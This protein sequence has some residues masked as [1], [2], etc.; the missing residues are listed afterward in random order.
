MSSIRQRL[1]ERLKAGVVALFL[2]GALGG[3]FDVRLD[4]QR[5][6]RPQPRPDLCQKRALPIYCHTKTTCILFVCQSWA[7]YR[8]EDAG[9]GDGSGG[10]G[11][12]DSDSGWLACAQDCND[13]F[14]EGE[15]WAE[16][17]SQCEVE[18]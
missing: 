10:N 4:A 6:G 12:G 7:Y 11:G 15:E 17:L 13:E 18:H 3:L 16:C 5:R 14:I 9:S 8:Q 1:A 2:L